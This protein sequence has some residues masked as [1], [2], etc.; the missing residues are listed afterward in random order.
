LEIKDFTAKQQPSFKDINFKL[1][2]GEILGIAGLVGAK[3]TEIVESIFGM[4][5]RKSGVI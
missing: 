5:E 2:K 1:R 4:R 3:R